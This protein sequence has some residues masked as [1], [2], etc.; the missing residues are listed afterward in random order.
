MDQLSDDNSIRVYK[1]DWVPIP[2]YSIIGPTIILP[3]HRDIFNY[4][5]ELGHLLLNSD[6]ESEADYFS[7]KLT[8]TSYLKNRG[9][10]ACKFA[11]NMLRIYANSLKDPNMLEEGLDYLREENVFEGLIYMI[12]D[13]FR[14]L[15]SFQM[16]KFH[17]TPK[18]Y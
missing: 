6:K 14:K 4:S 3:G 11:R 10:S 13:D 17:K 2:C 7:K 12:E 15:V 18:K 16:K 5:H 9:I 1:L 8:D